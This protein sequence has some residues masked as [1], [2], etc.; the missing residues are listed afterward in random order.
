MARSRTITPSTDCIVQILQPQRRDMKNGHSDPKAS[1]LGSPQFGIQQNISITNEFNFGSFRLLPA[2]RLL[3]KEDKVI[4]LG[5]RAMEILI[6]LVERPNELVSKAE[7]MARVWPNIFVEPANL[8]VSISALRRALG[9]GRHGNRFF[10]NIP[11]RG[12]RFVAPVTVSG[13]TGAS[14]PHPVDNL[15]ANITRLIGRDDVTA[16]LSVQ[17]SRHRLITVTGSGGVG[18][19]GVAL[20]VAEK[21]AGEFD[22]GVW[23]VDLA[24]ISDPDHVPGALTKA[25]GSILGSDQPV[26][27][28]VAAL[29]AKRMLLVLDN[30][31]HNRIRKGDSAAA[32]QRNDRLR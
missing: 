26:E 23:W 29:R 15:P 17:L 27:K 19:T 12:Y 13:I 14:H 3:L 8:T 2:Q 21:L 11:G 9:D 28:L 4:H 32:H 22:D 6:A 1:P 25:L 5:S 7:L 20:G 18:K 30:C 10:I 31:A 24:P 16:E